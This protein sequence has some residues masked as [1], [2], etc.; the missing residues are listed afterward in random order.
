MDPV[1]AHGFKIRGSLGE[2]ARGRMVC[3][4]LG[5]HDCWM[6]LAVCG[7]TDV[8]R[9]H[10]CGP[11]GRSDPDAS[12]HQSRDRCPDGRN[13]TTLHEFHTDSFPPTAQRR[14]RTG[15]EAGKKYS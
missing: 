10:R 8:V 12:V 7:G 11:A 9:W 1:C 14:R 3:F 4:T 2:D 13:R 5:L 6:R 15:W